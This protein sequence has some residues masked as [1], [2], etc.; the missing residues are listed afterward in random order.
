MASWR[1]AAF[2]KADIQ[3]VRVGTDLNVRLWPKADIETES[4]SP[5]LNVCL[6]KKWLGDLMVYRQPDVG[7]VVGAYDIIPA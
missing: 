2:P 4:K 7:A 5:F 6:R 1:M 3:N